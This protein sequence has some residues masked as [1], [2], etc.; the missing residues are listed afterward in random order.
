M[1]AHAANG[2]ACGPSR[3]PSEAEAHTLASS[4]IW[5]LRRLA[6]DLACKHWSN[7]KAPKV[8]S[9]RGSGASSLRARPRIVAP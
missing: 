7:L 3:R 2:G 8:T 1:W 5:G 4:R 6:Q 9:G